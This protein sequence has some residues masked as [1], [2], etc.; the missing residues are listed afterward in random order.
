MI[1]AMRLLLEEI[2]CQEAES[3]SSGLGV[4]P[5]YYEQLAIIYR[6]LGQHEE[7]LAV[8]ERYDRQIKA[9]GARP[10]LLKIRLEKVRARRSTQL[11]ARTN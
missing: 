4:A 8:L 10:A 3:R 7:E 5:W 1:H 6:K 2:G 11:R 9:P